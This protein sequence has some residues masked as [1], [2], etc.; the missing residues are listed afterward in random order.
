MLNLVSDP[1]LME[2]LQG[3]TAAVKQLK[4]AELPESKP[5]TARGS[6]SLLRAQHREI[7]ETVLDLVTASIEEKIAMAVEQFEKAINLLCTKFIVRS[8]SS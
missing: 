3:A 8:A 1:E 2:R 5:S 4:E 7:Y 6:A